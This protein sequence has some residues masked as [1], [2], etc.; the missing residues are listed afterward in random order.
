MRTIPVLSL[1][2]ALATPAQALEL[3]GPTL[4]AASNLGQGFQGNMLSAA[5]KLPVRDFRDAVY[6]DLVEQGAGL[7]RFEIDRTTYPDLLEPAGAR[8]SL[9]VNNGHPAYEGGHTPLGPAAV[10]AFGAH[11]AQTVLRFPAIDAV[12]VGNEFNSANF[13][14]GPLREDTLQARAEAYAALL[15]S[16]SE[17]V[18][19]VRPGVRIIG[20]GV[21][22]IPTGYLGRLT[23][24]GA[25]AHMDALALHPYSTPIEHLARQIAV[26]R[27]DPALAEMPVEITE[28]GSQDPAAAPGVLVRSYCQMALAGVSRAVW[29][30]LNRRGDGYV[31]LIGPDLGVTPAGQ[32]YRVVQGRFAGVAVEDIS[33]DPFTYACRFGGV[34]VILWGAER[35]LEVA[36]GVRVLD[37]AGAAVAP[38]FRLSETEPLI[39]TGDG[40][41]VPGEDFT[42]A[43]QR[44]VADS[45]HQFPYPKAGADT[46]TVDGFRAFAVSPNGRQA[47]VTMPGQDRQGE[48]WTPYL[49]TPSDRS[50]RVLPESLLPGGS[51]DFPVEIVQEFTAPEAMRLD[52]TGWIDPAERSV[53]GVRVTLLRDGVEIEAWQVSD[54]LDLDRRGIALAAGERLAVS[55]GPGGTARGDVTL[56]RLT[57]ARAE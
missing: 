27:R 28:F 36:P 13:V 48:P 26:M 12:E 29:Y 44:I 57:L 18:R 16:V 14:S 30:A 43:P 10:R 17:Q 47:L 8:M 2:L 31:P 41:L 22:S 25:A 38:P 42:L 45:Y 1:L 7:Y 20:G 49:G 52:L 50:V 19:A 40:P 15:A 5:L 39:L 54:R 32:A 6:W 55:V 3:R 4:A 56:Y 34:G 46:S 21:H 9:T 35:T 37:P 23:A 11:A 33:P 51:A 53:D 24:L